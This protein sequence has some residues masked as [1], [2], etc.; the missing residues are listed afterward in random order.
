MR[1]K[2]ILIFLF[3]VYSSLLA[4]TPKEIVTKLSLNPAT[5]AIMQ[6][7]RVFKSKRKMKK[8]KIDKLTA[9]EQKNLK[10]YLLAHA[11]DSDK[12][13]FAGDF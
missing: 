3:S 9:N 11:A 4:V 13:Q 7:K 2:I 5:K 1:I 8:Y 6:W 10:E 12:P